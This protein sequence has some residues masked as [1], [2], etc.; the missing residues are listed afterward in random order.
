MLRPT[1]SPQLRSASTSKKASQTISSEIA[2]AKNHGRRL[3]RLRHEHG[4]LRGCCRAIGRRR[5][6][7]LLRAFGVFAPRHI[8][9]RQ[10]DLEP[11]LEGLVEIV[12]VVEI[13][14]AVAGGL[15]HLTDGNE[16]EDDLAEIA[17]AADAPV[18]QH[19]LGHV[20]VLVE[21]RSG[22]WPRTVSWPVT[23]RSGSS[24]SPPDSGGVSVPICKTLCA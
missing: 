13:F 14:A 17:R 21:A 2:A 8:L 23:C 16:V 12:N 4:T 6:V 18:V 1:K 9:M 11:L 10:P 20:A 15:A 7:A 22:G 3:G 24:S 19:R 5:V